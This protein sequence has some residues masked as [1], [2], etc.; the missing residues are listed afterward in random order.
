MAKILLIET[1]T[2]V[3]SA[4]ISVDG[5]VAALVE[6]PESL[7]HTALLTLHIEACCQSAGIPLADLDAVA[8]SSG[9]GAY[10]SLRVG[11]ATAKGIC[12]SLDKPLIAVNTLLALAAASLATEPDASPAFAAPML[13]ARRQE[14]WLAV[15][16]EALR[17]IA[18][19]QPLIL[20]NNLFEN[21]L[22]DQAGLPAG[23][24]LVLSG[25]GMEKARSGRYPEGTVFSAIK[26]CS[27]AYLAPLAEQAYQMHDFQDVAY[28]GPLYM[29]PPNITTPTRAAF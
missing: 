8:V 16:D 13:D 15:Y 1:A 21:F 20:E 11:V 12:Y 26:K 28:F 6:T 7:Q 14:V 17:E 24:R 5:R 2:T 10:T 27:A 19:P 23:S 25:N 29:K 3:C 4:A 18:P 22:S 9:P